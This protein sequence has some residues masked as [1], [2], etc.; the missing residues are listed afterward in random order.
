MTVWLPIVLVVVPMLG[1]LAY[2]VLFAPWR[3]K[4]LAYFLMRHSRR[5]ERYVWRLM[6]RQQIKAA[7]KVTAAMVALVPATKRAA[8]EMRKF[9]AFSLAVG[10]R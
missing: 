6:V 5:Y 8:G 4:R 9:G 2:S 1:S 10:R 7:R 3:V